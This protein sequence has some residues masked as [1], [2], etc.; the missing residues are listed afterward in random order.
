MTASA[1]YAKHPDHTI[2]L[3]PHGGR[4]VVRF[5]GVVVA[6]TERAL[7]MREADYPVALYVP[8]AD[9]RMEHFEESGHATHCPF[10]GDA[11]YWTLVA[12]NGRDGG[13]RAENAAWGYDAPFDQV[14]EIA[15]Y[16]SFYPDRVVIEG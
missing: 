4:V 6:E 1:A 5:G 12:G 2:T 16:V 13:E 14:A 10:K 3:A 7:E 11:R 9:C 8:R 15:G